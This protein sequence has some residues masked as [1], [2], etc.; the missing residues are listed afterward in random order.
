VEAL[1]RR[2]DF[3][4]EKDSIVR[5]EETRLRK[6]LTEYYKTE[7][8]NELHLHFAEIQYTGLLD[9][10]SGVE[11]RRVFHV[12]LNGRPLLQ[13]FDITADVG[14]PLTADERVF[15]DVRPADDGFLHLEFSSE[16]G[17]PLLNA[18]EI[19]PGEPG[20][21]RP[22]RVMVGS[23]VYLN[24]KGQFWG[25]DRYFQGGRVSGQVT[26]IQSEDDSAL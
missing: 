2:P 24:K 7:G 10:E 23:R 22:V 16:H 1:G 4:P 26:P 25:A 18:L 13:Y 8:A 15:K 6:R 9:L 19:L 5:V 20:K 17:A 11:G 12:S 21:M 3:N 14:A